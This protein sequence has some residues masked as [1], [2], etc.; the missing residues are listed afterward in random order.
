[1]APNGIESH[2]L[3]VPAKGQQGLP[4]VSADPFGA[5]HGMADDLGELA[6]GLFGAFRFTKEEATT[7]PSAFTAAHILVKLGEGFGRARQGPRDQGSSGVAF[8]IHSAIRNVLAVPSDGF[9]VPRNPAQPLHL[10]QFRNPKRFG[11]AGGK[12]IS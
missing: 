1:M 4:T 11:L 9:L 7:I 5:F 3:G 10:R 2:V 6:S 12:V 8:Q